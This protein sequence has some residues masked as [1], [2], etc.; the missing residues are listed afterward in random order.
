M[1]EKAEQVLALLQKPG[2]LTEELRRQLLELLLL[3][4]PP[5]KV[6]YEEFL[7]QADEDTLAEW[8]DGTIVHYS[9]A[10][11]PHQEIVG[12]LYGLLRTYVELHDLGV[13]LPAPFQMKLSRTG[14]EP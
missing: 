1:D 6:S 10:S 12:F 14:R 13:V 4:P 9:P 3:S 2:V 5:R 11:R 8:V 7:A